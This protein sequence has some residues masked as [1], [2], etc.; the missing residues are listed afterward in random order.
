MAYSRKGIQP[1]FIT[2]D[3]QRDTNVML[4]KSTKERRFRRLLRPE[5]TVL[6][7]NQYHSNQGGR[8]QRAE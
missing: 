6:R 5:Q 8:I 3:P 7:D 1:L 2:V 4:E